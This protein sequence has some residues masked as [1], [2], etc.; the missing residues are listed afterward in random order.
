MKPTHLTAVIAILALSIGFVLT[1]CAGLD[2]SLSLVDGKTTV[3]L[4]PNIIFEK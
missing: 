2:L 1:G 3:A 4:R